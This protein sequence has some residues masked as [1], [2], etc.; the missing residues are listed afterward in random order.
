M[1]P[2]GG[3]QKHAHMHAPTG[4]DPLAGGGSP[5]THPE[6]EVTNLPSDL[7]AKADAAHTHAAYANAAHTHAESDVTG[8]ATDLAG[9]QTSP[10]ADVT[11]PA[12]RSLVVAGPYSIPAGVVVSVGAGGV[13]A[14]L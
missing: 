5:H 10:G 8:L 9:V 12:N 13:L 3:Y 2:I 11:V 14:I 6:S 7:N 1:P 4:L